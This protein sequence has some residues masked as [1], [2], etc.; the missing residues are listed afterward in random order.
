MQ[1][2][3]LKDAQLASL[4]RRYGVEVNSRMTQLGALRVE[5]PVGALKEL[6]ASGATNYISPDRTVRSFGHVT[7]TT[8]TDLVRTQPS[9][10]LVGGILTTTTTTLDGSG[11][12]IAIIDSGI[13]AGH[14]AFNYSSGGLTGNRIK[15]KK[16]F[17][18]EATAGDKDRYG[19]GA[20]VASSAAGIS[21]SNGNSYEGI[22]RNADTI[23]LRVLDSNGV[24]KTSD[25]LA[26]L[27]WIL[28]PADP[29][30]PLSSSNPT[31]ATKFNLRVVNM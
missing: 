31:N 16:D 21:Y 13:D 27:N 18:Y 28:S 30:K 3:D 24:G 10:S 20:H 6:A 17:T 4:F 25:L 7:A 12:G 23:S 1:A 22:A 15:F 14:R 29:T 19:H 26:A 9:G 11:I 5:V 8:G 2:D